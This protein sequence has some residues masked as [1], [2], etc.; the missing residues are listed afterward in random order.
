MSGPVLRLE[1][2]LRGE[3]EGLEA[4]RDAV[5]A[6]LCTQVPDEEYCLQ[7]AMV[8]GELVENAIKHGSW[9]A[10]PLRPDDYALSLEMTVSEVAITVRQP[11]LG[12]GPRKLFEALERIHKAGS[13][14]D[15][16]AAR[17]REVSRSLTPGGLGLPRIA[18]EAGCLLSA[19]VTSEGLLEVLAMAP[20]P[21]R[22]L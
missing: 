7:L 14:E 21:A 18:H 16:Y 12:A 9:A 2:R 8:A 17:M 22:T 6:A 1:L 15:A 11:A 13:A 19:R 5:R 20:L 4:L 10:R 3:W